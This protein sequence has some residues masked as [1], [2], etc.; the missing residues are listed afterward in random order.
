MWKFQD[1][2]IAQSLRENNFGDFNSAKSAIFT[3]LEAMK[4][5]FYE[6]LHFLKGLNLPNYQNSAPYEWQKTTILDL[7][8]SQKLIS[9]K[10]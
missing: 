1:F 8:D 3:H 5:D 2:S 4:Y 9:R 7:L 10:I 6:F